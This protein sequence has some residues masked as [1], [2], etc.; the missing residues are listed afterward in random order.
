M[1]GVTSGENCA[2]SELGVF[3]NESASLVR[4]FLSLNTLYLGCMRMDSAI[5]EWPKYIDK[6]RASFIFALSDLAINV[7]TI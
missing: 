4:N 5:C 3:Q 6:S 1:I 2:S 7:R